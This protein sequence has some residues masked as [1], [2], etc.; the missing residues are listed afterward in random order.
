MIAKKQEHLLGSRSL[1]GALARFD[2]ESEDGGLDISDFEG[3][4]RRQAKTHTTAC[5]SMFS[6]YGGVLRVPERHS[7]C[8][9]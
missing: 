6:A 9:K 8:N 3:V 1:K 2:D 4:R 5:I 7:E